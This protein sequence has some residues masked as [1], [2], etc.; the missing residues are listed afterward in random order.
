MGTH[1]AG[2]RPPDRH[3]REKAAGFT[4]IELLVVIAIIGIL[5]SVAIPQFGGYR[6]KGFD[7]DAQANVR[8][9]A[10]AQ[11]GYYLENNTYADDPDDL[12]AFGYTQSANITPA[13]TEADDATFVVTATVTEGCA[14][15]TG[16]ATYDQA[17][18]QVT[19]V[20]CTP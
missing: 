7:A 11:E 3:G 2:M 18:G 5:A 9:M 8:N 10:L 16:V 19:L 4:L 12:T 15:D 17:T 6:R 14:D 13:V 20:K 1:Q